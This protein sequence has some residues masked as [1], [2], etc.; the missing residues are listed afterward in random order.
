M[1]R[2]S[3]IALTLITTSTLFA[4]SEEVQ[5]ESEN[6]HV[7]KGFDSNDKVEVVVTGLLPSTCY[8]RPVAEAKVNGHNV[9]INL[10]ATKVEES[11]TVCILALIPYM[12]SVPLG[13]LKEGSY[14]IAVNPGTADFKNSAIAI[15]APNSQSIDNFTYANVQSVTKITGT[16]KVLL[17]GAHPSSCM[18]I[19][20]VDVVANP[21][22]DTFSIL[23][24]V[25]QVEPIC[26][27][28]IKPFT[29]E[30]E[31]PLSLKKSIVVHVRKIDGSAS[32]FL[33]NE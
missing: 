16:N 22:N 24:I 28:M 9:T 19:D 3:L 21:N 23:P 1:K 31:L 10:K 27:R 25:K 17:K 7:P 2:L 12:V 33:L 30:V 11:S 5:I 20:R 14:A 15:E 13:Q 18:V 6:I 4:R 32:N 29:Q 26:D 8:R